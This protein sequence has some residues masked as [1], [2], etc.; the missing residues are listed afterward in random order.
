M[1]G[2]K[3]C[4]A[5]VGVILAD[6]TLAIPDFSASEK[7][8]QLITQVIGRAG[9]TN[10]LGRAII[11]TY[12]PDNPVLRAATTEN[13]T[14]FYTQE[15]VER[16]NYNYPPFVYLLKA[17]LYRKNSQNGFKRAQ[18]K[19]SEIQRVYKTIQILGPAQPLR[20]KNSRGYGWQII[21][22]AKSRKILLEI[23]KNQLSDWTIELDPIT[24]I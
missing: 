16:A 9:R 18:E 3:H 19:A 10:N 20:Y 13:Y 24:I 4:I 23:A 12:L 1:T 15:L 21:I 14:D 5:L 6:T 8:F 17:V 22:K 2:N 11:Q 7:T